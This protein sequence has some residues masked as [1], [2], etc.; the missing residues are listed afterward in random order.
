M[1]EYLKTSSNFASNQ[2]KRESFD[3][4]IDG[5]VV[6]IKFDSSAR[7]IRRNEQSAAL[8]NRLQYQAMQATTN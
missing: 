6:K 2:E 3:Y 1:S 5:V 7:G 4:D 8:G